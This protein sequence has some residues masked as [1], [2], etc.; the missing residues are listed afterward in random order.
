MK[1]ENPIFIKLTKNYKNSSRISKHPQCWLLIPVSIPDTAIT[2]CIG[3]Q[4]KT[5]MPGNIKTFR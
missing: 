2:G 1:M 4:I 5:G 3:E